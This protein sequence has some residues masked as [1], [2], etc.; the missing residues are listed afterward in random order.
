[1]TYPTLGELLG[2]TVEFFGKKAIENPRGDARRLMA[3][4]LGITPMQVLTQFDRPLADSEVATLR[5]LVARRAKGEPLQHI[6][7]IVGFRHIEIACDA[8][9]LVPRPDTETIVD[10]ALERLRETAKARVHEVGVG[11]GC[12][13]LSLRHEKASLQ[14]TGSDISP[15]ALALARHNAQSLGIWVP[16][17][18]ANL[19]DG[20]RPEALDAVVSNPPYIASAEIASLSAEVQRDPLLALDGGP[21]GLD[22]I[23][24]LVEQALDRLKP[25]GWLLVEHGYDQ[26]PRTVALCGA[27]WES[28]ATFKDLAGLDRFLV[29]RKALAAG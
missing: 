5:D 3:K 23:R 19:L 7:G 12:I 26:G 20:I 11:T 18:R 16:L 27:G 15:D 1:M 14:V 2:K 10:L 25:G 13:A 29:A 8:R 24:L 4:G 6:L 28:A 22:L 21:D 17:W 9:A